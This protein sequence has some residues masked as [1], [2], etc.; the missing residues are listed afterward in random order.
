[1]I[2]VDFTDKKQIYDACVFA[3]GIIVQEKGQF[4]VAQSVDNTVN[5]LVNAHHLAHHG[6]EL[7]EQGVGVIGHVKD[8]PTVSLGFQEIRLCKLV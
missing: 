4:Q 7:G 8:L 3:V 5:N 1:M 2:W 6:F